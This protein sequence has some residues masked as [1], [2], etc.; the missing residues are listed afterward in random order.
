MR[1][2]NIRSTDKTLRDDH[3]TFTQDYRQYNDYVGRLKFSDYAAS[4][5]PVLVYSDIQPPVEGRV[6][7]V[8]P[9]IRRAVAIDAQ[10]NKYYL[11]HL[12]YNFDKPL[13][14]GQAIY[15]KWKS[16]GHCRF[17]HEV[18]DG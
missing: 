2:H 11:D 14:K 5:A 18:L 9:G 17:V 15:F 6:T 4:T 3:R 10:G 8:V 13:R 7:R 16:I 12:S 1:W